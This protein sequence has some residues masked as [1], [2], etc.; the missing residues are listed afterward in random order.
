MLVEYQLAD[1]IEYPRINYRRMIRNSIAKCITITLPCFTSINAFE[2][3]RRRLGFSSVVRQQLFYYIFMLEEA[4]TLQVVREYSR[5]TVY[6][7]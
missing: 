4:P 2:C 5:K 1:G 6:F 3:R 7:M